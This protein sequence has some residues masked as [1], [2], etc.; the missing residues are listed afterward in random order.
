MANQVLIDDLAVSMQ[1][2]NKGITLQ[3][4]DGEG[5]HRGYLK[6]SKAYIEW[7]KGKAQKPSSRQHLDKFILNAEEG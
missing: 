6:I 4:K 5:K 1:L 2:G 3:I 7:Y